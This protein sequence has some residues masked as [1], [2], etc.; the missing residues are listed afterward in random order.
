MRNQFFNYLHFTRKERNGTLALLF[1]CILVFLVP[2]ISSRFRS[3]ET[4]DF[5][6]FSAEAR[7]LR[8][9]M[10][11][12]K[13][14]VAEL[15]YFNPNTADAEDFVRLGLSEKTAGMICRYREK[16]GQFRRPED[17]RKIWG[18]APDD[19]E[20]LAPFIR[21]GSENKKDFPEKDFSNKTIKTFDFDPNT[22]SE[23]DFQ[24]LGL[25]KWTIKSI[26]NYRSKGGRFRRKEDF[27]K[28]YNLQE[29]DFIRLEPHIVIAAGAATTAHAAAYPAGN[30]AAPKWPAKKSVDINRADVEAWMTLPGI[31][32]KRAR[33]LVNYREKLGGFLSI[34]QVAQ[35]YNLPDSVFQSIRPLL[36]LESRDIRKINLNTVSAAELATHPYF[37]K[38]QADLIVNYRQ[39]HGPYASVNG[40]DQIIPFTDKVWLAK[41]KAYL[42]VE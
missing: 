16:G 20:R 19:Y 22:A 27:K 35:M 33:Q 14:N 9:S 4:T 26:I 29:K 13:S 7:A 24:Q 10:S 36:V 30:P 17:F 11:V 38:K 37:S 2:T 21:M 23:R 32:E 40:I 1:L 41:V 39:Q 8:D 31:G 5:S 6:E 15:F 12:R 3:P 34:E 42:V 28:I 18:L 25:P